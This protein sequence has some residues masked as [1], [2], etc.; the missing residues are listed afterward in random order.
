MKDT[1]NQTKNLLKQKT[2]IRASN[3]VKSKTNL[4]TPLVRR[5]NAGYL[6]YGTFH[7]L[8]RRSG[9]AGKL[10]TLLQ[11]RENKQQLSSAGK[12][13]RSVQYTCYWQWFHVIP[14]LF[15]GGYLTMPHF[16]LSR[17]CT[18]EY[19]HEITDLRFI[20]DVTTWVTI[21]HGHVISN[22]QCKALC[23]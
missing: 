1:N 19:M 2:P 10:V 3:G 18:R 22:L 5:F 8:T 6:L 21:H 17:D 9:V 20:R 15:T 13:L 14:A 4:A 11:A 16:S 7:K 12:S 23:L